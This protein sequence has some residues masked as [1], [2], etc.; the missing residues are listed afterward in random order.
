MD[1]PSLIDAVR[2][3]GEA[4]ARAAD[5]APDAAVPSCPEWDMAGLVG[6]TGM[7]HRWTA[8]V[9]RRGERV[10]RRDLPPPPDAHD[11]RARWFRG[12]VD[13]LA[14][15]LS[16]ADPDSQTW[17]FSSSGDRRVWWWC[18]RQAAETGTH[19]WD[20]ENAALAAQLGGAPVD[21]DSDLAVAGVDEYLTDFLPGV[22]DREGLDLHGSLHLHATDDGVDGEWAVDLGARPVSSRRE[23]TKADTAIRGPVSDL[24][25]WLWNRLPGGGARLEVFGSSDPVVAWPRLRV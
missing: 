12:G 11:E 9:V 3:E 20:A 10:S 5:T 15:V 6:H 2:R 23:H 8:E 17:T 22:V 4:L 16:G 13:E 14:G 1:A 7:V 25:L 18:R 24:L 21:L 19:R